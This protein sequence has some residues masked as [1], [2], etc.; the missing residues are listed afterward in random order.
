MR[1]FNKATK[2][3]PTL[4]SLTDGASET[5]LSSCSLSYLDS[6]STLDV[7]SKSNDAQSLPDTMTTSDSDMDED[8]EAQHCDTSVIKTPFQIESIEKER[9]T[10]EDV[11]ADASTYSKAHTTSIH[12][13]MK[14][15]DQLRLIHKFTNC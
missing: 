5:E 12:A 4:S 9:K 11:L 15:F 3:N 2:D 13:A 10:L 6:D 8:L 1:S 7:D 14:D